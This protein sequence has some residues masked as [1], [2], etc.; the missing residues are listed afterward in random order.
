MDPYGQT[1]FGY[2]KH[3]Q[4]YAYFSFQ[5]IAALISMTHPKHVVK[6]NNNSVETAQLSS[7]IHPTPCI[8]YNF[9]GVKESTE[10]LIAFA[11]TYNQ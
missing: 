7:S 9:C 10:V 2:H 4:N 8:T 1:R 11:R 3:E 5:L 6:K